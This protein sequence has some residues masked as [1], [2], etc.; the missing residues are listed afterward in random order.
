LEVTVKIHR[1]AIG[2]GL[3]GAIGL[4]TAT[5]SL[6][7]A[8]VASADDYAGKKYSDVESA[9]SDADE[10]GVIASRFGDTLADDDCVVS[11]SQQA[12]WIKG[13][14]FAPVTDTVLLYLNCNAG[15]AN[16]KD[17]GNSAASPEGRDAIAQAKKDAEQDQATAAS[18]Q[19]KAKG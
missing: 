10:T 9:L 2:L 8:G 17:P 1:T 14:D 19:D 13:D 18:N 3:A 15:V 5:L 11:H 12:P 4:S 7:G 16:A 6:L